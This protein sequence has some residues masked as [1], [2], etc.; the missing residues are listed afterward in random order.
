MSNVRISGLIGI[1]GLLVV[2]MATTIGFGY[3]YQ[4]APTLRELGFTLWSTVMLAGMVCLTVASTRLQEASTFRFKE[5]C[6][7]N[8]A[9]ILLCGVICIDLY[10]LMTTLTALV[11]AGILYSIT[12]SILFFWRKPAVAFQTSLGA[13]IA[14]MTYYV[15]KM[16]LSPH[17]PGMDVLPITK[18]AIHYAELYADPYQANYSMVSSNPFFYLPLQWLVYLPFEIFDINLMWVNFFSWILIIVLFERIRFG[19]TDHWLV[20]I[21]FYP[22]IA[23]FPV[24]QAMDGNVL[25]MWLGIAC[26]MAALLRDRFE[27]AAVILGCLLATNHL[28]LAIAVLAGA[29]FFR[30]LP[31]RRFALC[32]GLAIFT[33]FLIFLPFILFSPDF[34]GT[35]FFV[36]PQ[37]ANAS[38]EVHRNA[39]NSVSL[40]NLLYNFNLKPLRLFLQFSVLLAGCVTLLMRPPAKT[41]AFLYIAGVVFLYAV[42]LNGQVLRYYY[43]PPLLMIAWGGA[44]SFRLQP[45]RFTPKKER[46]VPVR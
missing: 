10:L 36:R 6:I 20:R 29:F 38:W 12:F 7:S 11:L 22:V 46:D 33:S 14:L 21:M 23:A 42:A 3:G 2:A 15:Y 13:L 30:A 25:P 16:S 28:I 26:F 40:N 44:L 18:A 5:N 41:A 17:D 43:Y 39:F 35:V 9:C 37:I 31:L 45:C 24:F 19:T 1:I 34:L 4:L 8:S 27:L 32:A